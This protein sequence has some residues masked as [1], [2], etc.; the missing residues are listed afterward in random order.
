MREILSANK[1]AVAFIAFDI[2]RAAGI[3]VT[4]VVCRVGP[5]AGRMVRDLVIVPR[6]TAAGQCGAIRTGPMRMRVVPAAPQHSVGDEGRHRQQFDERLKHDRLT[7]NEAHGFPKRRH[8]VPGCQSRF[9]CG[10][11]LAA[12]RPVAT[13][14][15]FGFSGCIDNSNEPA[16]LKEVK[17]VRANRSR[18]RSM[19]CDGTG[20]RIASHGRCAAE[21]AAAKRFAA[22][23][24]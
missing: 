3:A 19:P 10:C 4:V 23:A 15:L 22:N 7:A 14:C 20:R 21:H 8:V 16:E 2:A 9:F 13:L 6:T 18:D 12:P 17:T 5:F 11:T 24:Q 1:N